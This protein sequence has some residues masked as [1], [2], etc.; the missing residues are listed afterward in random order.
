VPAGNPNAKRE[1]GIEMTLNPSLSL[2]IVE[3]VDGN[4]IRTRMIAAGRRR[5]YI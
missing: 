1:R 5:S 4:A 2:G 3:R